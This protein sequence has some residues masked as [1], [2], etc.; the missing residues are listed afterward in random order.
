M[1][2]P[3]T[4][5]NATMEAVLHQYSGCLP[6]GRG[7]RTVTNAKRG[8]ERAPRIDAGR[9][10]GDVMCRRISSSADYWRSWRRSLRNLN[11]ALTLTSL[12]DSSMLANLARGH[13]SATASKPVVPGSRLNVRVGSTPGI[14]GRRRDSM[15]GPSSRVRAVFNPSVASDRLPARARI[16]HHDARWQLE[17]PPFNSISPAE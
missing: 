2:R 16:P 12:A 6:S 3:A 13:I 17:Q 11:G 10:G 4:A 1:A 15:N 14:T 5:A 7:T 9:K 8:R